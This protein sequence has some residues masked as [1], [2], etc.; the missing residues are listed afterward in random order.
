MIEFESFGQLTENQLDDAERQLGFP[1]PPAYRRWLAGT[2]GGEPVGVAVIP[3]QNFRWEQRAYGLRPDDRS[4]DLTHA[5]E[6]APESL[7]SGY[8]PVAPVEGG[9][10]VVKATGDQ[11]GSV[12]FWDDDEPG[13]HDEMTV[14]EQEALLHPCGSDW[15]EFR[16]RLTTFRSEL[17]EAQEAELLKRIRIKY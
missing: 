4:L 2:N 13:R 17:T 11:V 3:E 15:D 5:N 16:E 12:W 10:L 7:P 6:Y 1:L 8:L 9:L 14:E